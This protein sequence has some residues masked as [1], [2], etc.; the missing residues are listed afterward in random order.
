MKR[1]YLYGAGQ[2]CKGVIKFFGA[3][4]ITAIID[5]DEKKNGK[6]FDGIPIVSLQQYIAQ[7]SNEEI[8]I[9]S[10]LANKEIAEV[11]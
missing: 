9:T 2:N 8:I 1:Y 5:S 4:N 3:E 11:L 7:E 10:V 6:K